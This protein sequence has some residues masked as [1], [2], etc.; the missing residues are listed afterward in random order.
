MNS[1]IAL[2]K[3]GRCPG[4][5]RAVPLVRSTD[6]WQRCDGCEWEW[7]VDVRSADPDHVT[8]VVRQPTEAVTVAA[9]ALSRDGY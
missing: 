3:L 5:T 7:R 9:A 8:V 4:C 6:A 2:A 1:S